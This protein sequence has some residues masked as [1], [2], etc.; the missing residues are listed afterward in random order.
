MKRTLISPEWERFPAEIRPLLEGA[1]LYDSSCSPQARVLFIDKEDGFFLK[2]APK[3]ALKTESTMTRYFYSLGL[4]AE[5]LHYH[6]D[7]QDWLLTRRMPGEDCLD[8]RYLSDPKRL[9]DTT[10]ELLRQLHETD[11][12]HCPVN[13]TQTYIAAAHRNY[14][15]GRWDKTP[16]PADR[17][18]YS[19]AE[20]AW[21]VVLENEKYLRSDTLLHGDYCLP[22]IMLDNWKRSGFID[23]GCGGIGDRH[24]D[25]F[26]GIWSLSYNLKTNAYY[27][28]FLDAYGRDKIQPEKLRVIAAFEVFGE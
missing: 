14:S 17:W 24:I 3:G 9:C 7:D 5:V 13:R 28:R 10:A 12:S 20:E 16:F 4:G 18:G 6:S 21:N 22:N 1:A 8:S 27:D 11:T 26:W 25:L 15:A 19:S 2:S 23:V